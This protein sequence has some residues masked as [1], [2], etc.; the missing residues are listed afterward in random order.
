MKNTKIYSKGDKVIGEVSLIPVLSDNY[1]FVLRP[2]DTDE[3]MVV[4][5]AESK[6]VLQWL[7]RHHLKLGQIWNTHHHSDHV[8]GN[9]EL[10]EAANCKIVGSKNDRV[11]IPGIDHGVMSGDSVKW[12]PMT[13][14]V[15][16]MDGHTLGHIAYVSREPAIVFIGDT[17]FGM[18]CGRLFEG[19]PEQMYDSLQKLKALD[20]NTLIFCTHEYTL[21]NSQFALSVDPNNVALKERA[22]IV[23]NLRKQNQ[24][25][26]PLLL[27]DELATNPFLRA[28][29]V[30]EFA[31][32]RELRNNY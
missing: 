23:A 22:V 7:S 15:W 25:T 31:R 2:S 4:D 28:K 18:G 14:E 12:G 9:L 17:L 3:V 24:P 6:S 26:V 30:G 13:F 5:P 21:K 8:G 20:P 10:K 27:S 11:R 16:A 19:T 29:D 1:I 32:L